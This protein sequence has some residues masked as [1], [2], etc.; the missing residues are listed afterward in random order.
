MA[1]IWVLIWRQG[2]FELSSKPQVRGVETAADFAALALALVFVPPL[3][4][5][6]GDVSFTHSATPVLNS[7]NA[8]S[9][10]EAKGEI[11]PLGL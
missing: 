7:R 5:G 2:V 4:L 9:G 10:A 1:S 11:A 8:L 3:E 6:L